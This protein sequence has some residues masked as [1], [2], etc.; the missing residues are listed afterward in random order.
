MY[1]RL[2]QTISPSAVGICHQETPGFRS[3]LA[4]ARPTQNDLPTL[5]KNSPVE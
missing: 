1:S 4:V 3:S 5:G 2:T